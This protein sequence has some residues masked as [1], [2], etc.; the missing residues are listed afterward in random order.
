ML[1]KTLESPLDCKEIQPV[2]S[3]DQ[4]WVF[5]GKTDVEA[6]TPILWPPDA[7]SWLIGKTL[8]LLKIEGRRS[9]GRRRMRYSDGR[10]WTWVWLDFGSWW[11]QGGLAFIRSQRVRHDWATEVNWTKLMPRCLI[12]GTVS[13][14]LSE[15]CEP[16]KVS[17]LVCWK[18]SLREVA[19]LIVNVSWQIFIVIRIS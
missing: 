7:E 2:D 13:W 12:Q 10:L 11:W 6:E 5:T 4:S 9:R 16:F 15:E 1:E 19:M 8:M 18:R 14:N 3:K 17:T